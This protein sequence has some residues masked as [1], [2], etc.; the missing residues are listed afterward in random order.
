MKCA[1]HTETEASGFCRNCGKAM[2][3][4]CTREANGAL[5]CDAC[6]AT[7]TAVPL[8]PRPGTSPSGPNPGLAATLGIIP[9]LGAVY[10]GEYVKAL[11]HVLLF[12]GL[13]AV[14][15]SDPNSSTLAFV[16]VAFIALCFYMPVD[17][18]RVARARRM[19]EPEPGLLTER[20]NRRPVGA[21]VLIVIGVL[22]LLR[23]FDVF[24]LDWLQ[25]AWPVGVIAL[26]VW[27][28]WARVKEAS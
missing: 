20:G 3:P 27:L 11:I 10:N 24:D 6:L 22:I 12:A 8:L 14:M 4:Q 28:V 17:A 1:V 15:A 9:G 18:Y 16:I 26:G 21:I 2:C 19:G 25:K 5:Y 7:S 23:N 13:I